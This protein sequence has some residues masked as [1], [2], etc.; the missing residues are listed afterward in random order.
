MF[1][2]AVWRKKRLVDI[3]QTLRETDVPSA[4]DAGLLGICAPDFTQMTKA[5]FDR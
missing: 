3:K 1:I 2:R 4:R 5:L